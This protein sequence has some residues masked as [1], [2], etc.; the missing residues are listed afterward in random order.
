MR[1]K[2]RNSTLA[3]ALL[4]SAPFLATPSFA[5][6]PDVDSPAGPELPAPLQQDGKPGALL[7][8]EAEGT[9]PSPP[10]AELV[11]PL[12][13]PTDPELMEPPEVPQP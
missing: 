6:D 10:S 5:V 2:L 1:M 11:E 3:L 7:D 4:S 12:P 8:P 9:D 13:G